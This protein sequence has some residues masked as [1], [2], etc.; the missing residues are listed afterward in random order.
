MAGDFFAALAGAFLAS[1]R[2][3][4][5]PSALLRAGCVEARAGLC[6]LREGLIQN[7][8]LRTST[9]LRI[10]I[11]YCFGFVRLFHGPCNLLYCYLISNSGNDW[12]FDALAADSRHH[13][14]K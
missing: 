11:P 12:Q 14:P 4:V 1:F 5:D 8:S 7:T 9:I 2:P 6:L 3:V 13:P 10:N